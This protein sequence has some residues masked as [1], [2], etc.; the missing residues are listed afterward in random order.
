V[1]G[2]IENFSPAS[3]ARTPTRH[4]RR[5]CRRLCGWPVLSPHAL[6]LSV[7]LHLSLILS[8]ALIHYE[9]PPSR[10]C[11][12]HELAVAPPSRTISRPTEHKDGTART[13]GGSPSSGIAPRPPC[14]ANQRQEYCHG[15]RLAE[16]RREI[17]RSPVSLS[18]LFLAVELRVT[19]G[20]LLTEYWTLTCSGVAG[21]RRFPRAG[22]LLPPARTS[23]ATSAASLRL[24][25]PPRDPPWLTE[26][27]PPTGTRAQ[28]PRCRCDVAELPPSP[29]HA[30]KP[31]R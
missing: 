24:L 10:H 13:S 18:P 1:K 20:N 11:R 30:G 23:P 27:S 17:R 2:K 12:A 25:L 21:F 22:R 3:P 26:A 29:P 15:R 31:F 6:L 8:L 7:F 16:L 14:A 9:Q 19:L 5:P 4:R 28:A